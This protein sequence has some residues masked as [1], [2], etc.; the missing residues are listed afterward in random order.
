M[1]ASLQHLL[2]LRRCLV[3]DSYGTYL[4]PPPFSAS[5]LLPP[6]TICSFSSDF[7]PLSKILTCQR[8]PH[9]LS[10]HPPFLPPPLIVYFLPGYHHHP[11]LIP[12]PFPHLYTSLSFGTAFLPS[13]THPYLYFVT[14]WYCFPL[15][16]I[17]R[18]RPL[19][20]SPSCLAIVFP[21]HPSS[22]LPLPPPAGP[23]FGLPRDRL[24]STP[25]RCRRQPHDAGRRTS[26]ML[27]RDDCQQPVV[28]QTSAMSVQLDTH[29]LLC[30]ARD[31]YTAPSPY[32]LAPCYSCYHFS[33]IPH[34]SESPLPYLSLISFST[35]ISRYDTGPALFP[36]SH[37]TQIHSPSVRY[38]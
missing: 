19:D 26:D 37:L 24:S 17:H 18:R 9:S 36:R 13:R 29:F 14:M 8:Y 30:S 33:H 22:L 11:P 7:L 3:F 32:L 12:L 10:S 27:G 20:H 28:R 34:A 6:F 31:T 23:F 38:T 4:L 15:P 1:S 35:S 16:R 25:R 21:V 5:L 2:I